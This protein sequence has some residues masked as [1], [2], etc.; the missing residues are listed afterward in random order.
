MV[1]KITPERRSKNMAAIRSKGMKPENIVR[2]LAHRLGYRFRLHRKDL[3][4][5]PDLV[6]PI[7]NKVIFV[8]ACFWHQHRA[9]GCVDGRMPKSRP[10]YWRPKLLGNM[11][12]DKKNQAALRERGW[13]ILVVWECE[14][15]DERVL[16][17]RIRSFLN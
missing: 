11:A 13:E 8:H 10:E 3:P 17:K 6:Y 2:S 12:R 7:R 5:K 4:G 9:Q 14:T 15:G 16:A 1:D